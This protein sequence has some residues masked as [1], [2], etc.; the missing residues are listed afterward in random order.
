MYPEISES[1]KRKGKSKM[2]REKKKTENCRSIDNF[3]LQLDELPTLD[4]DGLPAL[5]LDGL[6]EDF[7]DIDKFV[8]SILEEV[9]END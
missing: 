6:E 3:D 2:K 5:D 7:S 8:A 1:I 9:T 4:L